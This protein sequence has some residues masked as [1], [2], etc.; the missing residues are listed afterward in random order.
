MSWTYAIT[1]VDE[2]TWLL[3]AGFVV[4]PQAG[5]SVISVHG[6]HLPVMVHSVG[7]D[8]AV[9]IA[10]VCAAGVL[11]AHAAIDGGI[12]ILERP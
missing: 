6:G 10:A 1:S 2:S 7:L 4:A 5:D 9:N 8:M 11:V 3:F 12:N